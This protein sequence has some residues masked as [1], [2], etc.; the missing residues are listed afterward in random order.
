MFLLLELFLIFLKVGAFTFGGG[1]AMLPIIQEEI[2][3]KKGWIKEEDFIN[4]LVVAQ[5]SPGPIAINLSIY[6]GHAVAGIKGALVASLGS[7]LPSFVIIL[8]VV[9]YLYQYRNNQIVDSVFKGV[10]PAIAGLI[11]AAVYKL[12]KSGNMGMDKLLM[13]ILTFVIILV[14]N[15]T[16]IYLIIAGGLFSVIR[17]KINKEN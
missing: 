2:V 7:I 5:S 17:Y 10:T 14:F 4:S 8:V 16:P 9:K 12:M 6:T 11:V 13:G 1:F 3:D 15:I